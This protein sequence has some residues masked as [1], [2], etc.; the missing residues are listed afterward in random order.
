MPKCAGCGRAIQDNFIKALEK[1]WHAP[2]FTCAGC[3]R[4]L[5]GE[6]FQVHKDKPY[7]GRCFDDRFGIR[8]EGCGEFISGQA[9]TAMGKTW[10]PHCFRC[11]ECGLS[12]EEKSFVVKDELPY[13]QA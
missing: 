8:C 12:I 7:H 9:S 2:C 10:H 6:R 4:P 5:G 3:K 1:P 11:G 13:H